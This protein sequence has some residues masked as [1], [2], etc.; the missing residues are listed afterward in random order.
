ML[1]DAPEKVVDTPDQAFICICLM[2]KAMP[3]KAACREQFAAAGVPLHLHRHPLQ[4]DHGVGKPQGNRQQQD[5][6]QHGRAAAL[7][8]FPRCA[9]HWSVSLTYAPHSTPRRSRKRGWRSGCW[10]FPPSPRK[11]EPIES[12]S[13]ATPATARS[14]SRRSLGST[15]GSARWLFPPDSCSTRSSTDRTAKR[16][17][18]PPAATTSWLH[19]PSAAA[20]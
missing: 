15:T 18:V 13:A 1:L 10:S 8:R 2:A 12:R 14:A 19:W 20:W 7:S 9:R 6:Q 11:R 4:A 3:V 17:G 5:Y 16:T